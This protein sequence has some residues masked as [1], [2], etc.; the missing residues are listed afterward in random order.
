M[1]EALESEERSDV[2][3]ALWAWHSLTASEAGNSMVPTFET[4]S[5][6]VGGKNDIFNTKFIKFIAQMLAGTFYPLAWTPKS[7]PSWISKLFY[8]L[9]I[10]R[11]SWKAFHD[12][13]AYSTC[14]H[15]CCFCSLLLDSLYPK[16]HP[17]TNFHQ[18]YLL[19]KH[20][21]SLF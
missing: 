19:S 10:P 21:M 20:L 8:F 6:N 2:E 12:H 18:L 7:R 5:H 14:L 15:M 17:F 11:G 13:S 1:E 3:T 9:Q 16:P 4:Y